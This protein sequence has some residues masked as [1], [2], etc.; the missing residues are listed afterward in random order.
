MYGEG[1][2]K[3]GSL[4]DIGIEHG[5]IQ[6]SGAWF[7]YGD[8][9]IGQGRENAK[10]FLKE[11]DEVHE[12]ILSDVYE[13]LGLN[14]PASGPEAELEGVAQVPPGADGHRLEEPAEQVF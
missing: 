3:E 13:K 7:A 4:L 1:I 5:V 14:R 11:N 2:S 8:E 10:Q 9:R 6:K 12:Q